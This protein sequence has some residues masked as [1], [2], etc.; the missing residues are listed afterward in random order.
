M[1]LG[2]QDY[3]KQNAAAYRAPE[4]LKLTKPKANREQARHHLQAM[5]KMLYRQG[6]EANTVQDSHTQA[7]EALGLE[8]ANEPFGDASI[9]ERVQAQALGKPSRLTLP[10]VEKAPPCVKEKP[11]HTE[12]ELLCAVSE[13]QA[14][15]LREEAQR[16]DIVPTPRA[17]LAPALGER[18]ALMASKAWSKSWRISRYARGQGPSSGGKISGKTPPAPPARGQPQAFTVQMPQPP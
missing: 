5:R 13:R 1:C 11:F 6:A 8:Q 2:E 17:N 14:R 12:K 10:S 7:E 9:A 16:D 4:C 3:P 18:G 15:D